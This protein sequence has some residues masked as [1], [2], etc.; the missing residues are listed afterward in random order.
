M[1]HVACLAFLMATFATKYNVRMGST[2][3]RQKERGRDIEREKERRPGG[4]GEEK[5]EEGEEEEEE[6]M[7]M[8]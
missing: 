1:M 3:W 8:R 4:G 7:M 6:M 5:E 2:H